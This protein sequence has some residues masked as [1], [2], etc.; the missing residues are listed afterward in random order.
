MHSELHAAHVQQ[1]QRYKYL[2][3]T[4]TPIHYLSH[5]LQLLLILPLPRCQN[6]KHLFLMKQEV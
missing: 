1:Y 6:T 3:N 5:I 4:Q 2:C